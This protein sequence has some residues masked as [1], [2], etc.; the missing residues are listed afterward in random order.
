MNQEQLNMLSTS[1]EGNRSIRFVVAAH[2][3]NGLHLV[4][5]FST[6]DRAALS[7]QSNMDSDPLEIVCAEVWRTANGNVRQWQHKQLSILIDVVDPT[8][9]FIGGED[10]DAVKATLDLFTG[11]IVLDNPKQGHPL[12]VWSDTGVCITFAGSLYHA[13]LIRDSL[14]PGIV[15]FDIVD[16]VREHGYTATVDLMSLNRFSVAG[17]DN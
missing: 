16:F 6:A 9:G 3:A 11:E 7:I 14:P 5:D 1:A 8:A 12:L 17:D 2:R 13:H 15:S 4:A 10:V